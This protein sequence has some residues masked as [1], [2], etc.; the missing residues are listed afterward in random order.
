VVEV[1][2][3]SG[4]MRGRVHHVDVD[5]HALAQLQAEANAY[6]NGTGVTLERLN[7]EAP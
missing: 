4:G 5:V 6:V 3:S 7:V 1:D 2:M